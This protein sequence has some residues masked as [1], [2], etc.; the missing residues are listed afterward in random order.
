MAADADTP[1]APDPALTNLLPWQGPVPPRAHLHSDAPLLDLSGT[2]RFRLVDGPASAPEG[3]TDPDFDDADF[4]DLPVPS[5]WQMVDPAGRAPYGRPAYLNINYPIPAPGPGE[6]V[7]VPDANP[8]GCYRHGFD[9][10]GEFTGE[11]VERVLLRF[12]GVDSFAR[13]WLNGHDLGWTKGSRLTSEF[14]VT[15]VLRPGRNVL[16]VRVSQ[17]SDA[18]FLEDQDMWWLSGI[19]RR[20]SLLARPRGGIDD[21]FVHSDLLDDGR[22]RLLVDGPTDAVVRIPELD[23]ETACNVEVVV[24]E[25]QPW[26]AETPN[27]YTATVSTPTETVT[28]RVGF[29]T[30]AIDG[31]V[32]TVNGSK[33]VLRG[34]NRHEWHPVTGRTLDEATMRADLDLMKSHG[35]NAIRTSHYPPDAR[36]LDLCD[37]YG[38]W[39][40]LENDLETHGWEP[41]D[42]QGTP[43]TEERWF[44][45]M[46]NRMQRAVERDK[47]HPCVISWSLGNES[48]SGEGVRVMNDWVKGRD[49]SRFTHYEGDQAR[50]ITDVWSHMYPILERVEAIRDHA[51][52]PDPTPVAETEREQGLP[53]L[54]CEF[55]HAMGNGPGEFEEYERLG[56]DPTNSRDRMHGGFVW[57]WIDHG[58]DTGRGYVYGG[59][60]GEVLHDSNFVCDGLVMPDRTPSPGL[61]EFTAVL[62]AVRIEVDGPCGAVTVVNR[63]D[64]TDL[65]DVE[66]T[67]QLVD[68]GAPVSSGELPVGALV[69]HGTWR[70]SVELTRRSPRT[71]L[72]VEARQREDTAWAPAGHVVARASGLV[73]PDPCTDCPDES[74]TATPTRDGQGWRLGPARFDRNGRLVALGEDDVVGPV[75]DLYR[76][77]IDNDSAGPLARAEILA[78]ALEAG[79]HRLVHT[80]VSVGVDDGDLVVVTRTAAAATIRSMMTTWRWRL[81]DEGLR[82]VMETAPRG[83]WP[84]MLGRIGMTMGLPGEWREVSWFG[85]GPG[86]N[87]PDSRRA[88]TWGRWRADLDQLQTNYVMPQENGL[89]QGVAELTL[90]GPGGGLTITPTDSHRPAFAARPWTTAALARA[91]HTW[92][93]EPDG[94]IWLTLDAASAPLGST[95]CGP[96]PMMSHRL[97]AEPQRLSLLLRPV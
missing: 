29:R 2:W 44:P 43:V 34:V 71:V 90:R 33:I 38:V 4:D 20:V 51:A 63:R 17:W 5:C 41:F 78:P 52:L 85:L 58:I 86:E 54:M 42:W 57:E 13:V 88:A 25:V 32:I 24:D 14:D 35:V 73:D 97:Y 82:L 28:V 10:P 75:L 68:D 59:D 56:F 61:L 55:E 40:M 66:F 8:T 95:S 81:T 84:V 48:H 91:R 94:H 67:W 92:E 47:N 22:G 45:A 16:A 53:F 1:H 27:L 26:T 50:E 7:T 93:L 39:V 3:F 6:P 83:S 12:E 37:E 36:F 46:L 72:V 76:A 9:L 11:A 74:P 62:G 23:V 49:P 21:L 69:A 15:D 30:V 64:F 77:P 18:T 70:G 96:M 79:L 31:D 19:F 89:R 60:F 80:T 87:Y 65:S